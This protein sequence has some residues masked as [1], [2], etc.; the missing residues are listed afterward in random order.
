VI[1]YPLIS[2][3]DAQPSSLPRKHDWC[4]QL[5]YDGQLLQLL[6][7]YDNEN[8]DQSCYYQDFFM[9]AISRPL[10]LPFWLR[11]NVD[12]TDKDKLLKELNTP[13]FQHHT[14]QPT[15]DINIFIARHGLHK[16]SLPKVCP[17]LK[18]FLN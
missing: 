17:E 6:K 16:Q 1:S 13:L 14:I 7:K 10:P 2:F 18:E 5:L 4:G 3:S 15:F 8:I 9:G 12:G 11:Q